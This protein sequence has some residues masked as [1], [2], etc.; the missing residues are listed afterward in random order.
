[1]PGNSMRESSTSNQKPTK[2]PKISSWQRK[3]RF[4]AGRRDAGGGGE[5]ERDA[6][7]QRAADV[8]L[9]DFGEQRV[10]GRAFGVGFEQ[11]P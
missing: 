4:Y 10:G 7:G 2:T 6:G 9:L 8:G 1:M 5:V 3:Y 11:I